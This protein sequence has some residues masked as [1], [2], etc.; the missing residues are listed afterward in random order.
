MS[1]NVTALSSAPISMIKAAT[2]FYSP[3]V[4]PI[5]S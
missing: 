3:E 5:S 2:A 1:E 4:G